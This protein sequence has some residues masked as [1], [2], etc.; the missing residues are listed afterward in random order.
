MIDVRELR[1]GNKLIF[2]GQV[3]TV[4]AVYDNPDAGIVGIRGYE[5]EFQNQAAEFSPIPIT[6]DILEKCG[7]MPDMGGCSLQGDFWYLGLCDIDSNDVHFTLAYGIGLLNEAAARH[8]KYIH[9]LQNIFFFLT[10]EE[11]KVNL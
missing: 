5:T 9:Q 2:R 10:G 11:L 7:F 3:V 6:L 1:I 4:D 8:I